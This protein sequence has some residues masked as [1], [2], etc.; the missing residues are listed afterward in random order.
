MAPVSASCVQSRLVN[1]NLK[2]RNYKSNQIYSE[3]FGIINI[4]I[5]LKQFWYAVQHFMS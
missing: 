5:H 1:M 3:K 2:T 4:L